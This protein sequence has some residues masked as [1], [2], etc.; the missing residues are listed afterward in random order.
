M[1]YEQEVL[2]QTIK[3]GADDALANGAKAFFWMG[4]LIGIT[5]LYYAGATTYIGEILWPEEGCK[6]QI[7]WFWITMGIC[8][9]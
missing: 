8:H 1:E 6:Y 7:F 4:V 9:F 2:Y 3:G 5:F